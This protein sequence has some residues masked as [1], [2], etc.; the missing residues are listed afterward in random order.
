MLN[1]GKLSTG[2]R[3][4]FGQKGVV[5]QLTKTIYALG[6]ARSQAAIDGGLRKLS[7]FIFLY[8]ECS[9]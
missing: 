6:Q 1:T 7:L 9:I 5:E 8:S 3:S 2:V 4:C